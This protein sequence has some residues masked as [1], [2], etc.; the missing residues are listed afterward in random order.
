MLETA[1]PF[2]LALA[3]GLLIGIERERAHADHKA[4]APF[5]ARTFTLQ[6]MLGALAAHFGDTPVSAILALF[7]AGITVSSYFRSPVGPQDRGVGATTEVAAMAT[8]GL[9]YLA[10]S[11]Q[12]LAVFLGV[13]TITILALKAHIHQFASAWVNEREMKAAVTFLII[14]FVVLPLLP[15]RSVDPWGLFNPFRLWL[16]F[17]MMAGISF[18]G[19]VAVRLLGPARGLVAGGFFAGL[20]SS[21]AATLTLSQ[22]SHEE[23]APLRP[24]AVGILLANVASIIA[25]LAIIGATSHALLPVVAAVFGV[26]IALGI[27]IGIV[28]I[29]L[30]GR[31]EQGSYTLSNPLELGPTAKLA[32]V[33]GVV[34]LVAGAAAHW[35]GTA[36][37][38]VTALVVGATDVHAVTLAV[39]TLAASGSL[40]PQET[41]LALLVAFLSNMVVKLSL[42]AFG[43]GRRMF[44]TA[45]PPLA[46]LMAA[47]FLAW[48]L[49]PGV[50]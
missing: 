46:T 2:L 24:L 49:V 22:R 19:Y 18:G 4:H 39:A 37:I 17:V 30:M 13:C 48:I 31:S 21:T 6:A 35:F 3:I 23:K 14:A 1:R 26:P 5:G 16:V 36:G 28:A 7:A 45:G 43:G 33:L 42:T 12:A 9:G 44:L 25:M 47:A 40:S 15:N 11:N 27:L 29:R 50:R 20:A 32:A 38:M 34:L 41:I 10:H 8:F